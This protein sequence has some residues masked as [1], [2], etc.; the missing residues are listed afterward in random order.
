MLSGFK[1][2][3]PAGTGKVKKNIPAYKEKKAKQHSSDAV[4][5][6]SWQAISYS[7]FVEGM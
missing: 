1:K 3:V 5:L 4:R 7:P 2:S 6:D